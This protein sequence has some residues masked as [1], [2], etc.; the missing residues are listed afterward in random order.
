M[1]LES[2]LQPARLEGYP[3]RKSA[4]ERRRAFSIFLCEAVEKGMKRGNG[5]LI[6]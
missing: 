2:T 4:K 1:K 5:W 6:K 3:S